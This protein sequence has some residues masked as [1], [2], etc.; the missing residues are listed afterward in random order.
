MKSTLKMHTKDMK[1]SNFC[2]NV[3]NTLTEVKRFQLEIPSTGWIS[4]IVICQVK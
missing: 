1:E 3:S 4:F 2:E